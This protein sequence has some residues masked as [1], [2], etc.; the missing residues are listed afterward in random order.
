[1]A[2]VELQVRARKTQLDKEKAAWPEKT[3]QP[4]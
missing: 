4:P 3:T 1:M 2:V